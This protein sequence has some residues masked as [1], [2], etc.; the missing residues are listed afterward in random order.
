MNFA[1]HT[2]DVYTAIFARHNEAATQARE[3]ILRVTNVV[4][5]GNPTTWTAVFQYLNCWKTFDGRQ[6]VTRTD[7]LV[8]VVDKTVGEIW[9]TMA[10][11]NNENS[12]NDDSDE[13]SK[14]FGGQW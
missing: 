1:Q 6:W 11:N 10:D 3:N 4:G 8:T 9:Q 2:A 13:Q 7:P 14:K 12:G 5:R